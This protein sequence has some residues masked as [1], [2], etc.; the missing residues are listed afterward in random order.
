MVA[1]QGRLSET[2]QRDE[3]QDNL[4]TWVRIETCIFPKELTRQCAKE[5][6]CYR[7]ERKGGTA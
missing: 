7:I 6:A 1:Q 3:E 2:R 4:V 5:S